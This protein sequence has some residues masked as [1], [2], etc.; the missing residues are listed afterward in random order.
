MADH[1]TR[2][3]RW[4]VARDEYG[5]ERWTNSWLGRALCTALGVFGVVGGLATP[6]NVLLL[7]LPGALLLISV[8]TAKLEIVEG[9]LVA[10]DFGRVREIPLDQLARAEPGWFGLRFKAG[11]GRRVRSLISGVQG[12]ELWFTRA[13]R[14]CDEIMRRAD[15]A[16]PA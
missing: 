6:L 12:D 4:Q 16:R 11:D 10:H 13:E 14:I 3:S 8:W 15:E 5:V 1:G 9:V 2:T 7:T